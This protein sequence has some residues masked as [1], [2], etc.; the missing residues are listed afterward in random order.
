MLHEL[1]AGTMIMLVCTWGCAALFWFIGRHAQRTEKPAHFWAGTEI[2]PSQISDIAAYNHANARMWKW[3]SVPYWIS[4]IVSCFG[5]LGN[6]YIIA[7]AAILF[8]ACFPGL[9]FLIRRY[10]KIERA[11]IC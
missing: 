6:A 5:F 1:T 8:L 3:Y 2:D 4:G 10:R 11:Y 7:G 9:Y